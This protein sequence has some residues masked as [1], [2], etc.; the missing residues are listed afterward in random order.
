[1]YLL[2]ERR[3]G[4]GKGGHGL[5]HL[6]GV[7]GE[8]WRVAHAVLNA[9]LVGAELLALVTLITVTTRLAAAKV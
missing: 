5:W 6:W 2:W 3:W 8:L 7:K 1:M 4:H 9:S